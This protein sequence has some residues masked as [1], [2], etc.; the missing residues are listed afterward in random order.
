MASIL[1]DNVKDSKQNVVV[2]NVESKHKI[3]SL[4][5]RTSTLRGS[6]ELVQ[7]AERN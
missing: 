3:I 1:R 2:T 5:Q 7:T 4:N 6:A